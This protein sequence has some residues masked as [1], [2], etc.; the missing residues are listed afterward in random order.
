M[1]KRF[2]F[3][4]RALLLLL[5][6]PVLLL[7]V[8]T[9]AE[10]ETLPREEGLC[11]LLIGTDADEGP[12]RSDCMILCSFQPE[13]ERLTLTSLLR[14]LWVKIPGQGEN[15]LNAAYALGGSPLLKRTILENL[16]VEPD[17]CLT[18][19]FRGFADLVDLLGGVELELTQAEA[20]CINSSVPGNLG[21]GKQWLTGAQALAYTRIRKIDP[22]GDFSRTARQRRLLVSLLERFRETSLPRLLA[23]MKNL[24][25]LISTDLSRQELIRM[26]KRL[27][28]RLRNM[29]IATGQIPADGTYRYSRVRD[30]SVIVADMEENRRILRDLTG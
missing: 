11:L 22:D 21:T 3:S 6:L 17:G 9:R 24:L 26:G 16:R 18:V 25:P 5:C 2:P 12:S 27:L 29:E 13:K 19:D 1:K 14:D 10:A 15:R 8:G 28:P 30:M 4:G 20:D 23:T 7:S